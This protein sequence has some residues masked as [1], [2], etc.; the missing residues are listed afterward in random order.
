MNDE[1]LRLKMSA[2]AQERAAE[3]SVDVFA[4][5]INALL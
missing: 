1:S 2:S 3:F 5:R 4:K